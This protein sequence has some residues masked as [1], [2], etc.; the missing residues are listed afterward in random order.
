MQSQCLPA[1]VS[2]SGSADFCFVSAAPRMLN[3]HGKSGMEV[4]VFLF[5]VCVWCSLSHA[6]LD[7]HSAVPGS[8]DASKFILQNEVKTV[9]G[10][11]VLS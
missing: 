6:V 4:L 1:M 3:I 7:P 2:R 11:N 10:K 9:L 5:P 8:E